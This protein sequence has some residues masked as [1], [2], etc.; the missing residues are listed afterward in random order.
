MNNEP[1][2][3]LTPV[4]VDLRRGLESHLELVDLSSLKTAAGTVPPDLSSFRI[5]L[6]TSMAG[7]DETIMATMPKLGLI[8]C[9]G[10]GLDRIDLRAAARR[11][12]AVANT[13]DELTED[14]A[15]FAIALLYATSRRTVEADR[16]VR[17]GRWLGARMEPSRR[18]FGK[19]MGIVG[20]G[21]IGR[22]V[23]RRAV[24]I[25]MAVSYSGRT[26]KADVPYGFE[27]DPQRLAAISDVLVLCCS[28]GEGTRHLVNAEVLK[29]LGPEGILINIA[30][31]SVVDEEALITAL[32]DRVVGSAGLDVFGREPAIDERFMAMDNVVVQPHYACITYETRAAMVE[33]ILSDIE[34]FLSGKPFPNAASVEGQAI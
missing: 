26:C 11:G 22:A 14:T 17:S 7:A 28:G 1:V 9:N 24:G 20:L 15:D 30:R 18:I 5:A 27:P 33:R 10:A 29:A 23:A 25:G 32:Q 16:F 13:S 6:T 34:S 31:G 3:V 21:K 19:R 12:I 8:A 2:L 4:P